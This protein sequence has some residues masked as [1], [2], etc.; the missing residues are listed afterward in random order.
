MTVRD[1]FTGI[2]LWLDAVAPAILL[3]GVLIPLAGTALAWVGKKGNSNADG[4]FIANLFIGFSLGALLLAVF[5]MAFAVAIMD[6]DPLHANVAL[7]AAPVVCTV[8]CILGVGKVFP[9]NELASY[10]TFTDIALF[11]AACAVVVWL[12]SKFRGWGILFIG[13]IPQLLVI[14]LMAYV[15]LRR[16]YAR[17]FRGKSRSWV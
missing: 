15:V 9:V 10:R 14:G 2:Y 3:A 6:A 17:A 4:R 13:G 1:L 5:A 11:V 7:L 12:F 16:L 8:G